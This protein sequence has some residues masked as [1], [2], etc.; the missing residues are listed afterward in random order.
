MTA[1]MSRS[2]ESRSPKASLPTNPLWCA[3]S[4]PERPARSALTANMPVRRAATLMP[5]VAANESL[6]FM[7]RSA[8]P[9]ADS[10]T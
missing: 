1:A 2:S 7:A 5:T 8:R 4:A 3:K 6:S 10:W 9:V